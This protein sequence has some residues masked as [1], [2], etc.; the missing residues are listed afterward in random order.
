MGNNLQVKHI[1][2]VLI[3]VMLLLSIGCDQRKELQQPNMMGLR[4]GQVLG[5]QNSN[6]GKT[7]AEFDKADKVRP[8]NFPADH[9]PHRSFASEW[10]YLTLVMENEQGGELGLQFTL[11]R[12]ALEPQKNPLVAKPPQRPWQSQQLY[13]AHLSLSHV[14][15][16]QHVQ[17]QRFHREHPHNA[18]VTVAL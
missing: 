16:Q 14:D 9:G 12:Q 10:W 18:T 2:A 15:T 13:L 5:A 11:F 6:S 8:F 17:L 7:T 4:V 1:T 3:S